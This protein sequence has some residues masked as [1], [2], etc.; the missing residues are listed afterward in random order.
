VEEEEAKEE[1]AKEEEGMAAEI[2]LVTT[3]IRRVILQEN[4]QKEI[5]V[6]VKY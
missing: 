2:A 3:V 4:V 1:E 5:A 6:N